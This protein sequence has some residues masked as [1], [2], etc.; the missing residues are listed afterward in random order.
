MTTSRGR[1]VLIADDVPEEA[2][3]YAEY[4]GQQ[5]GV[6]S[7]T[8][9]SAEEA[10][11]RLAEL[12]VDC[13]VSDSLETADGESLVV[14]AKKRFPHL[15]V[16]LHSGRPRETLPSETADRYLRKGNARDGGTALDTLVATISELTTPD[17]P[18]VEEQQRDWVRFGTYDWT[19]GSSPTVTVLQDIDA[20]TEVDVTTMTPLYA[21]VEP[22][23]VNRFLL[24]AVNGD[25]A[26]ETHIQFR[27]ANYLVRC[28]VDGTVELAAAGGPETPDEA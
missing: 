11:D 9:L 7:L 10:L 22:D 28:S 24:H 14:A 2:Q 6:S 5:E 1:T 25:T 21:T 19:D 16:V 15:P 17:G 12:G 8:A 13:L 27:V 3:L 18:G 26:G 20:R 23:V 4:V